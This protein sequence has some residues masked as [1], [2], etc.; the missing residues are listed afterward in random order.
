MTFDIIGDIHGYS[1]S[2]KAL[3]EKLGHRKTDGVYRHAS[4]KAIF[5]GDFI[6][7]GPFQRETLGIV[8]PMI[9]CGAALSV[10]GNHEYNAIAYSTQDETSGEFLRRHSDKNTRQHQAFLDDYEGMPAEY[11]DAIAWFKTLPLWLDLNGLKV[12]H[13]CWDPARILRIR[14]SQGGSSLL[15]DDLLVQS[16]RQEQWQFEA[17]DTLL[18]GK[19]VPLANGASFR[20]KDGNVRHNIRVRWWDQQATTYKKAFMGPESA[21]THIPDD[22]IVGDHLVV[23]SHR[24]PP[25]VLGHY[26]MEGE[27]APLAANIACLD[28]SV[29]KPGGKLVAYRWDGESQLERDRFVWVERVED[30]GDTGD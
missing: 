24:E 19:E 3:L 6:D 9:E 12:V 26:W 27:P 13:A 15:G 1:L 28:Y 17:I 21:R 29:A 2:L 14:E 11:A 5:L 8:R 16:S 7:R 23:Y 10:M 20:D 25:V 30:G 22:E 18:K 4:R